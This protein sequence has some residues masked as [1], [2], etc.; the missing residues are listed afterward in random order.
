MSFEL[1]ITPCTKIR[2]KW[3]IGLNV[4]PETIDLAENN[5]GENY[6]NFGLDK[7]FLDSTL[8]VLNIK[9]KSD[10]WTSYKLKP[11]ALQKQLL[12]DWKVSL[13]KIL[14]IYMIKNLGRIYRKSSKL[15]IRKKKH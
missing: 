15:N 8:E 6:C 7:V 3:I 4:K 10:N 12:R 13:K 14:G 5:I 2:S 11:L 9:E 1:Y